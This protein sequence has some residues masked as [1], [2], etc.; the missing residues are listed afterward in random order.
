MPITPDM[1]DQVKGIGLLLNSWQGR[2]SAG[3]TVVR[4][5]YTD[6][7]TQGWGALDLTS[8]QKL[9]E[10]WRTEKGLHI[11]I[12]ELK[13]AI[14]AVHSLAKKGETVHL[15]IDNQVAYSYL[16]KAGGKLPQFN[17]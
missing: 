3:K 10:F 6:S 5:I 15:T 13:A 7:S 1:K 16:R 2:S 9:H 17:S 11:N 12:K 4:K 8:G 14:S